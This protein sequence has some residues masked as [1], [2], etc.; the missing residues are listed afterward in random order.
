MRST[1]YRYWRNGVDEGSEREGAVETVGDEEERV[2]AM[3]ES[4]ARFGLVWS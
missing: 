1:R 4:E 2:Y 3:G